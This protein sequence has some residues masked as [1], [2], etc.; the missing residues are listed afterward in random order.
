MYAAQRE[1]V[2][3]SLKIDPVWHLR[4][5]LAGKEHIFR[6]HLGAI[7]LDHHE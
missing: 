7:Q 2:R 5:H 1:I 4:S 6:R 3:S